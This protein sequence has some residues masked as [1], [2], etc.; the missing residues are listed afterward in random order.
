[1]ITGGNHDGPE[2][3]AA[4]ATVEASGRYA[5]EGDLSAEGDG[6][7][8]AASDV[9]IDGKGHRLTGD[10]Q[11][12]GIR[13]RDGASGVTVEN[14]TV[15]GFRRG[16]DVG[17]GSSLTL[18]SVTIEENAADGVWSDGE[19][20][21]DCEGVTIR[22]NGGNGVDVYGGQVSIRDSEI[23]G[24]DG[25]AFDVNAR[26]TA[27]VEGSVVA[28]NG[29]GVSLPTTGGSRIERTLIEA[30]DG[31]GIETPPA[32]RASVE[33][34]RGSGRKTALV[35]H[36]PVGANSR[37]YL[38]TASAGSP[39]LDEPALVRHCEVRDNA[40]PGVEHTHGS[41]AV[42]GCALLG[43]G[44]GY[45]LRADDEFEAVLRHNVIEGNEDGG[46]IA[47]PTPS[48]RPIDATCNWWDD[49]TGPRHRDNPLDDPN[50]QSVSDRVEF[51]PWS[52]ERPA[53]PD[54]AAGPDQ[55]EETEESRQSEETDRTEEADGSCGGGLE[56]DESAGGLPT[57]AGGVGYLTEK[58]YRRI[59]DDEPYDADCWDGTFYI[60]DP[61]DVERNGFDDPGAIRAGAEGRIADGYVIRAEADAVPVTLPTWGGERGDCE[62]VLFVEL[63]QALSVDRAYRIVDTHDLDQERVDTGGFAGTVTDV[64]RVTFEPVEADASAGE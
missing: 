22:R 55:S 60:T 59:A 21:I 3:I 38:R 53:G 8:I 56:T 46:V 40:G 54:R 34:T 52:A 5:L 9:T 10:G 16:V 4:S 32:G 41:L 11:R 7:E 36:P 64:I 1:M 14:L 33:T 47:D 2:T 28:D 15:R 31:P 44:V 12:M 17:W 43:N 48:P 13:T 27:I 51:L 37:P 20:T 61:A 62:S 49:E 24:N 25:R 35:E 29:G 63:N 30:N 23:R 18:S 57:D 42:R 26:A 39:P 19:A 45:R 58:S 6:I 50:G